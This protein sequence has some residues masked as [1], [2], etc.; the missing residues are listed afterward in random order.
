MSIE[1]KDGKVRIRKLIIVVILNLLVVCA[2]IVAAVISDEDT[3]V[4]TNENN[5]V[6]PSPQNNEPAKDE[7]AETYIGLRSQIINLDPSE[8]GMVPSEETPNVWGV[9]VEYWVS[10]ENLITQVSLADGTTSIYFSNG[11]GILGAGEAGYEDVA[12]ASKLLV[13][14]AETVY[15]QMEL[16]TEFPFCPKDEMQ[17]YVLTFSGIYKA[18]APVGEIESGDHEFS[19][20]FGFA[21]NVLTQVRLNTPDE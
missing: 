15:S 10:E 20:L 14:F 19:K 17:F 4:P 8:F 12:E 2:I 3:S 9:L 21:N 1:K 11:G 7:L 16:T 18:N 5:R 13:L 6:L